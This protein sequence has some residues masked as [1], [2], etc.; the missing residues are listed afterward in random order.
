MII[1]GLKKVS[2]GNLSSRPFPILLQGK[3]GNDFGPNVSISKL[4]LLTNARNLG[5]MWD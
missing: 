1:A 3:D 2:L 4:M 5:Y